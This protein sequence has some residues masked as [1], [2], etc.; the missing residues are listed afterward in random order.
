MSTIICHDPD[1]KPV[2]VAPEA[3][4][5]RPAAYGIF[6]ENELILLQKQPE[7][8]LWF[9][10]GRPL[11][12]QDTPAEAIRHHFR[13]LIG[14]IPIIGSFL[15]VTEQYLVD[16]AQNAWR[17]AQTYYLVE[18]PP[19]VETTLPA[20]GTAVPPEWIRLNDLTRTQ[21][22]FGYDAVQAGRLLLRG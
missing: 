15:F 2:Q 8:G 9:P 18:R 20:V 10:P 7:S 6:I 1:G 11:R 4:Q 21:M 22:Q 3:L 19:V 13:Q 17:E 14:V 16:A 12:P 5:F